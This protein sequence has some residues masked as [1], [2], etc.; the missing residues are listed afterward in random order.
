VPK[1]LREEYLW[2]VEWDRM[3]SDLTPNGE[4]QLYIYGAD[5]R[6]R[7]M[8]KMK[9][10]N[11]N[12]DSK[13]VYAMSTDTPRA[14]MSGQSFMVGFYPEGTGAYLNDADIHEA[15]PPFEVGQIS[16]QDAQFQ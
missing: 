11:E 9:F 2:G 13:S 8:Q 3:V 7:Y 12:Y 5:L 15:I 4:R 14:I 10:L 1:G 6:Y 16:P